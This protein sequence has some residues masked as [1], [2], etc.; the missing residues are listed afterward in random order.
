M[1]DAG[2]GVG[3][4]VV[5]VEVTVTCVGSV[6]SV[7]VEQEVTA[8]AAAHS[9][10]ATRELRIVNVLTIETIEAGYPKPIGCAPVS[11]QNRS[12]PQSKHRS[13]GRGENSRAQQRS[14]E[15]SPVDGH[16][17]QRR[18]GGDADLEGDHVQGRG[19]VL[20]RSAREEEDRGRHRGQR[21]GADTEDHDEG[22]GEGHGEPGGGRPLEAQGEKPDTCG[23]RPSGPWAPR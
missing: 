19:P 18:A 13:R 21:P 6:D 10:P 15:H 22:H 1:A 5:S 4:T 7:V 20:V 9:A 16:R 8:R 3:A 12:R 2:V 11:P 23:K 17:S 14:C